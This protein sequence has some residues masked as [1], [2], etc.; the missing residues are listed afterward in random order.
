MSAGEG[1]AAGRRLATLTE[2][3]TTLSG[4]IDRFDC[5]VVERA[6]DHVVVLYRVP[7]AREVHGVWL[8]AGT[9]TLGYFWPARPY[10]LYHWVTPDG[11]TLAHYFNIGDVTRLEGP[12]LHWRDLAVDI[13]ATPDGRV[14]VLDEDEL[15]PDLDP[16]LRRYVESAR[17]E[18]LRCLPSLIR[19]SEARAAALLRTR[20]SSLR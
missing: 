7:A 2:I 1:G 16:G 4:R 15:P 17:D 3:K 10:N 19:E 14:Q 8:P 13:L 20:L 5:E 12:N 18:V 9:V 6:D 11:S